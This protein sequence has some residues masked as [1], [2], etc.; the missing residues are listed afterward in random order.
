MKNNEILSET[1]LKKTELITWLPLN[2][3]TKQQFY[4]T[5]S[6]DWTNNLN[7]VYFV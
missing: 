5:K 7:S 1:N 3:S 4:K 6:F 2:S